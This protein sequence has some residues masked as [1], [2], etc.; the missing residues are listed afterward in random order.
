MNGSPQPYL[1]I[2]PDRIEIAT[3]TFLTEH[4][5]RPKR[6]EAGLKPRFFPNRFLAAKLG[7]M[8]RISQEFFHHSFEIARALE[9]QCF[10]AHQMLRQIIIG[11]YRPLHRNNFLP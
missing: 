7:N 3:A 1:L 8:T 9:N 4:M 11:F 5:Q 2:I 6:L 10:P